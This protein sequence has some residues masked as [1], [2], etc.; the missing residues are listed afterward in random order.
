LH[1]RLTETVPAQWDSTVILSG[2]E[3]D[4]HWIARH[5]VHDAMHHSADVEMLRHSL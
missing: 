5:A 2:E 1:R 4:L 3:V